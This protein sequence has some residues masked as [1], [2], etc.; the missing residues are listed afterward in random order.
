MRKLKKVP[1]CF[2]DRL[3]WDKKGAYLI[4]Q[5]YAILDEVFNRNK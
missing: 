4:L 3:V 1:T 2:L 5:D